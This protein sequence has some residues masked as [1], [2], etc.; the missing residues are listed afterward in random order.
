MVVLLTHAMM[1][2]FMEGG[3]PY[4][5]VDGEAGSR[6]SADIQTFKNIVSEMKKAEDEGSFQPAPR[7]ESG[8]TG[9]KVI[10]HGTSGDGVGR[11]MRDKDSGTN[12]D[13]IS[14]KYPR[15]EDENENNSF[16]NSRVTEKLRVRK[17]EADGWR[18]AGEELPKK[19][20]DGQ[21]SEASTRLLTNSLNQTSPADANL[22]KVQNFPLQKTV[23]FYSTFFYGPW[24]PFFKNRI[25]LKE[26]N[27]PVSSCTFVFNSSHPEDADAVIFH[28]TAFNI[29]KVPR[30]RRPHQRYIWLNLEAPDLEHSTSSQIPQKHLDKTWMAKNRFFNWTYTY[31]RDSDLLLLYGGLRSLRGE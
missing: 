19:E 4:E 22:I 21:T 12:P 6:G 30:V 23:L 8:E 7:E 13:I 31:H 16:N 10:D 9:R 11:E 5:R 26:Q 27:C 17:V 1:T 18:R 28:D 20:Y 14:S 29:N 2:T 15:L 25:L 3:R 24:Q